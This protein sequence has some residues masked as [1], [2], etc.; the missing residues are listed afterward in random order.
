M[1]YEKDFLLTQKLIAKP[2]IKA[3]C[4]AQT[5]LHRNIGPGLS[6]AELSIQTR[7]EFNRVIPLYADL[8]YDRTVGKTRVFTN[9]NDEDA[10]T[11]TATLG[12]KSLF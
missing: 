6:N 10:N 12:L 4:F 8:K 2:N 1:K 11:F 9:R 7:Y 5:S 3:S